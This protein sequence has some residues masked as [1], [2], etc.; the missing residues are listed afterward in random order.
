MI[1]RFLG[2]NIF[3]WIRT[4]LWCE[5]VNGQ[6]QTTQVDSGGTSQTVEIR[7]S[8]KTDKVACVAAIRRSLQIYYQSE[9]N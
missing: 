7:L 8:F 2:A 1:H 9:I 3:L 4:S 5:L 6:K